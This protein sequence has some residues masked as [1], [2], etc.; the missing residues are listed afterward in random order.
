MALL[1]TEDDWQRAYERMCVKEGMDPELAHAWAA[2]YWPDRAAEIDLEVA[3]LR[4][5]QEGGL[6]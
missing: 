2:V 4:A 5:L 3:V 1:E 6:L